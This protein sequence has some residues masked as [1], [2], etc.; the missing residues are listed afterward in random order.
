ME[1]LGPY[2][3]KVAFSFFCSLYDFH[4][5]LLVLFG[6]P[7]LWSKPS[8]KVAGVKWLRALPSNPPVPSGRR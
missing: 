5:F 8:P 1:N 4:G 7:N 3:Y 2:P 6:I